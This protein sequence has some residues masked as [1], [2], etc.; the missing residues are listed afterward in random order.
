MAKK[1]VGGVQKKIQ[2]TQ[3]GQAGFLIKLKR[4]LSFVSNSASEDLTL[5]TL[6]FKEAMMG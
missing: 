5:K 4:A 1:Q 2:E 3:S 6:N